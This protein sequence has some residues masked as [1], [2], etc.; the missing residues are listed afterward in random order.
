MVSGS[1]AKAEQREDLDCAGFAQEFLRRNRAY[2]QDYGMAIGVNESGVS[3]DVRE[4]MARRWGLCFSLRAGCFAGARAGTLVG[5][6]L[7]DH[8]HPRCRTARI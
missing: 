6:G 7:A 2:V 3:V 8:R 4:V 1:R 5:S